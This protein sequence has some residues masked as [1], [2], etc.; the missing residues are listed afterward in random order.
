M[1]SAMR[2]I[3]RVSVSGC[4]AAA[5]NGRVNQ[6]GATLFNNHRFQILS[7]GSRTFIDIGKMTHRFLLSS[8]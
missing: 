8:M 6:H 2:Q 1:I 5:S 4:S 3:R 7:L